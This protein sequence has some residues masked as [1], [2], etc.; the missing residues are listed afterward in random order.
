MVLLRWFH[1]GFNIVFW[2]FGFCSML[3]ALVDGLSMS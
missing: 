2:C 1:S 3:W